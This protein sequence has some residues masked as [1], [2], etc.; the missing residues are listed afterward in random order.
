MKSYKLKFYKLKCGCTK[1]KFRS[2]VCIKTKCVCKRKAHLHRGTK[3]TAQLLNENVGGKVSE[4][5]DEFAFRDK[6]IE[7]KMKD[8]KYR[9]TRKDLVQDTMMVLGGIVFWIMM[10]GQIGGVM[11]ALAAW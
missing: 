2:N 6:L 7:E 3:I 1:R 9:Y 10:L 5:F 11:K 4:Y 8:P